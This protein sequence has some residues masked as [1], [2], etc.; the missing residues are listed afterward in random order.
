LWQGTN[1]QA[2][3]FLSRNPQSVGTAMNWFYSGRPNFVGEELFYVP[4][5]GGIDG[6]FDDRDV[7]N[8]Q[9]LRGKCPLIVPPVPN[10]NAFF[11]HESLHSMWEQV[12]VALKKTERVVCLGYSFPEGDSHMI[13]LLQRSAQEKRIRFDIV[14]LKRND[15]HLNKII[16]SGLYDFHQKFEGQICIPNFVASELIQDKHDQIVTRLEFLPTET[17]AQP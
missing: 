3:L 8:L 1:P 4:C 7:A 2:S 14:D 12:E 10:K 13:Q 16:G 15:K 11:Q 17:P 5:A 6:V 9:L